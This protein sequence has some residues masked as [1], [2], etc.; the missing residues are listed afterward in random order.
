MIT[1]TDLLM[2]LSELQDSGIDTTKE[3]TKVVTSRE[4]PMDVIKFINDKRGFEVS[5]FYEHIRRSYNV[6]KSKL[7]INIMK[8]TTD[9]NDVLTTLAALN[10]QIL[11]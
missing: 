3:F 4:L 9:V 11:L 8:E 1:K 5:G 10:L 6:K 7:Y 2:L